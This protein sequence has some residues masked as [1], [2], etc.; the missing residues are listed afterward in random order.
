MRTD[1]L[2]I[3]AGLVSIM[4]LAEQSVG[5]AGAHRGVQHQVVAA[6]ASRPGR[7]DVR[8]Q[9]RAGVRQ[10]RLIAAPLIIYLS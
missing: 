5:R 10:H 2:V 1:H 4:A 7:S 8:R 6:E 3:C 9:R